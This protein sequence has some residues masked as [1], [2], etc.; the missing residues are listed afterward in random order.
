MRDTTCQAIGAPLRGLL[1]RFDR[2]AFGVLGFPRRRSYWPLTASSSLTTPSLKAVIRR[3]D[4]CQAMRWSNSETGFAWATASPS[5]PSRKSGRPIAATPD[6][7]STAA[8]PLA[9]RLDHV[10]RLKY[11]SVD[12][13]DTR[14]V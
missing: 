7:R 4:R 6:P 10:V 8:P 5:P 13:R 3:R 9:T 2:E 12:G 14:C 1:V 11:I